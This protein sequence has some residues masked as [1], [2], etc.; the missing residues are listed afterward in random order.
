MNSRQLT[1]ILVVAVVLGVV[2]WVIFQRGARSWES[3]PVL[4]NGKVV[5]FQLND[6]AHITIKEEAIELNLVKKTD[7]WVVSERAD[8]PANFEQV[9]RLLQ[10]IWDL[11][12]VQNLQVG[13]SQFARLDLVEPGTT[14]K[15]GTLLDLKNNNEKRMAALLVGKQYMRKSTQSF[16]EVNYPAGRYVMAEDGSKRV[17]LVS[18]A[19]Q[20]VTTKPERWLNHDFIKIEKP[21][22]ISLQATTPTMNW[23]LLR[24][25]DSAEWKFGDSKPGEE[26]DETKASGLASSTA[27]LTFAD[28]LDPHATANVTG[29]DKPIT[30]TIETFDG[31]TY[32]LKIGKLDGDKYPVTLSLEAVLPVQSTVS[33]NEKPEEKKKLEDEFQARK[34]ALEA[35]LAKEKKFEGRPFLIAKYNIQ[36]VLKNRVDLIKGTPSPTPSAPPSGQ[37]Q[38]PMLS[39]KRP[40]PGVLGRPK[41]KP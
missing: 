35:K 2:G 11:K 16:G 7:G 39:P 23:K 21:K 19:L 13:P 4:D 33:P 14:A 15:S 38:M 17:A 22:M 30:A 18:D 6:V 27:N 8:Y 37:P 41:V 3:Q 10:K 25:N 26:V 20:D 28:V 9:S 1:L 5:N 31:F 34:K 32:T 36:Q 12:P 40:S 29:L 24:E